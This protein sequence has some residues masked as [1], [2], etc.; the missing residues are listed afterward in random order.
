MVQRIIGFGFFA[1]IVGAH[2]GMMAYG[3]RTK[4]FKLEQSF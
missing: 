3:E 2:N 4:L 1:G